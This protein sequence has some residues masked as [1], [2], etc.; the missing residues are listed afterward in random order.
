MN[1][2]NL[3]SGDLYW[4]GLKAK[5]PE[6]LDGGS[7]LGLKLKREHGSLQY[8]RANEIPELPNTMTKREMYLICGKVY[9]FENAIFTLKMVFSFDCY[10]SL[11]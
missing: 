10:F 3:T 6:K 11:C 7:V 9:T 2:L 8:R 1:L 5:E 4:N